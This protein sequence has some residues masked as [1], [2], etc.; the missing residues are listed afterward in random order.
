MFTEDTT[1]VPE[2]LES[3]CIIVLDIP[4][5]EYHEA[6]CLAQNII[7]LVFQRYWESRVARSEKWLSFLYVDESQSFINSHDI[8]F[9]QTAR[10][11][12]VATV[13]LT[14]NIPNYYAAFGGAAG[15]SK[16]DSLLGNLATK[17]F[18]SNADTTTNRY[19]E[20][21]IGR[22]WRRR[23]SWQVSQG[24]QGVGTNVGFSEHLEP[25][26]LSRAFTML[27][28]GGPVNGFLADGIVFKAGRRWAST[29]E[30]YLPVR[31]NQRF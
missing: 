29:T 28:Q 9:L 20:E 21:L 15:R 27:R 7:K 5:K 18:L 12:G 14:Q 6:G 25:V 2:L 31:F 4:T 10:E 22:D 3:G 19:A 13:F 24:K 26:L 17:I 30:N 23:C 16:V 11:A 8:T 1:F